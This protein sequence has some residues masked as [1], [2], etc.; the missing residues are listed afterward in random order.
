LIDKESYYSKR[1]ISQDMIAGFPTE[2][3]E[4]HKD[5]ELNEYV[6]IILVICIRIR[7]WEHYG[8][9]MEDDVTDE[10]KTSDYKKLL[11]LQQKHVGHAQKNNSHKTL[12]YSRKSL[13]K[14]N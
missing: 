11:D 14:I 12:C 3:E 8:R 13:C 2:T 1:L 9:K 10:N 7:T 4:D 6:N 5:V